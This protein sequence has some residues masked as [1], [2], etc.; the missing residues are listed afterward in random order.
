MYKY[1]DFKIMQNGFWE[2]TQIALKAKIFVGCGFAGLR[3]FAGFCPYWG[4]IYLG[5][6]G[7][8][9]CQISSCIK[10]LLLTTS[11]AQI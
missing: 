5:P 1:S 8:G 10:F 2:H 4:P 7:N 9:K 11:V 6:S 3:K